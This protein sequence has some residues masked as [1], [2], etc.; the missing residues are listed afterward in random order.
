MAERVP[1]SSPTQSSW[2][3]QKAQTFGSVTPVISESKVEKPAHCPSRRP[4]DS[5]SNKISRVVSKSVWIIDY[6]FETRH[7]DILMPHTSA[8]RMRMRMGM[9]LELAVSRWTKLTSQYLSAYVQLAFCPKRSRRWWVRPRIKSDTEHCGLVKLW[10]C[11][12]QCILKH[13]PESLLVSRAIEWPWRK[14]DA[15][16]FSR[17]CVDGLTLSPSV[18]SVSPVVFVVCCYAKRSHHV[19]QQTDEWHLEFK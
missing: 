14:M 19:W 17:Y 5:L 18:P 3:P 16:W 6:S 4:H 2:Q 1:E 13:H 8:S 12:L 10:M 15:L 11:H 7:S 9:E